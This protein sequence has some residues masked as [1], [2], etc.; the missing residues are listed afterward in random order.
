MY[1]SLVG[2]GYPASE[3]YRESMFSTMNPT[4]GTGIASVDAATAYDVTTPLLLIYNSDTDNQRVWIMPHELFLRCTAINTASTSYHLQFVKRSGNTYTSGGSVLSTTPGI[5]NMGASSYAQALTAQRAS[6]AL[7]YFGAITAAAAAAATDKVIYRKQV[8]DVIFAA[9]DTVE[10]MF[11]EGITGTHGATT[12][13]TSKV[14]A[15]PP[16][17]IGPGE[18]L[19]VHDISPSQS[20]DPAWEPTLV[21]IEHPKST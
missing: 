1:G 17:W 18:S 19:Q 20:A 7:V 4:F 14:V 8:R 12:S 21:W 13:A 2:R 9:D 6:M 11:G 16:I 5:K 3:D 15:C 10:L